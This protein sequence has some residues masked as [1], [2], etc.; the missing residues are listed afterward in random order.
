MD[1]DGTMIPRDNATEVAD[2]YLAGTLQFNLDETT[3]NFAV[4]LRGTKVRSVFFLRQVS[5]GTDPVMAEF[6]GTWMETTNYVACEGRLAIPAPNHVAK[7]YFLVVRTADTSVPSSTRGSWVEDW[8]FIIQKSTLAFD[9]VA[10]R[11]SQSSTDMKK[12]LGDV[13]T[14]LAVI[15]REIRSEVTPYF[16]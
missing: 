5:G 3:D 9:E 16:L 15:F 1:L 8:D 10:D 11:I 14:Q 7:P 4:E 12:L 2:L 6:E 13:L